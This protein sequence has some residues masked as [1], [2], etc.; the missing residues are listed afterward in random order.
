MAVTVR[1]ATIEDA[2]AVADFAQKLALQHVGY[3]PQRFVQIA[4]SLQMTAFYGSQTKVDDAAVI[5]AEI[6]EK[7]VGFAYL[8][9]E[10][11]N[12]ADLLKSA[13]WIH[14]I[15]IDE[16]ARGHEAGKSLI[17]SS[18]R[19]AREMGATKLMLSAAVQNEEA[20]G[21]FARQG[22]KETM[23][24]MMLSLTERESND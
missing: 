20:K 9:F 7:I 19:L 6:G 22:F 24:E 15:Y 13:V 10:A 12:Y 17:E 1:R 16:A 3:D 5:V 11:K 2:P 18:K 14:D 21:F 4:D 8:Q 23:V